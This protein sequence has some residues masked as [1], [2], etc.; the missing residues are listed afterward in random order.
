MKILIYGLNYAP[1]LTGIG[2]YTSDMAQWLICQGHHV[3]VIT[4][5]PYYPQWKVAT[6][7]RS[8]FYQRELIDGVTIYRCPLWVPT[9]PSGLKRLIHLAS[10][11]FSS[12]PLMWYKIFWRPDIVFVIEPPLFCTPAAITTSFFSQSRSWLHVQDFEVD[13]AFDLGLLRSKWMKKA[14]L[15]V[16]K[17]LMQRFDIVSTISG[18]MMRSLYNKGLPES[19]QRLFPNWVDT[20]SIFPLETQSN[21]RAELAIT[22]DQ[23]VALYSGNMGNKQG[24]DII[25]QACHLLEADGNVCIV[26]CGQGAAYESLRNMAEDLNNI[27]WL[28]LQ[29]MDRLNE[30]LNLADI[31]LLP[32]RADAAD[33]VMPSKLTGMLASGRPIIATASEDTEIWSVVDGRGINVPPGDVH[34][35]KLAIDLLAND[36]VLRFKLGTAGRSYAE[37]YLSQES[38][39]LKF[40]KDLLQ[41]CS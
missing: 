32:Q 39:L 20:N 34:A 21:F 29:P 40:E 13:A 15:Y 11:A 19:R 24:L 27:I 30:L 26:M 28:P 9:R 16:E 14:V 8:W 38:V 7:Y 36:S 41:L 4:A 10:F 22:P 5:P 31:H 1:E 12:F 33:L 3:Q 35:F 23:V 6:G 25:I 17:F 18:S 2:K 37:E